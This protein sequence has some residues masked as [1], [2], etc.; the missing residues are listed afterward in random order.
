MHTMNSSL[1]RLYLEGQIEE[2]VMFSHS[3]TPKELKALLK[4]GGPK[5]A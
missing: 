4:E 2:E 3:P 1:H 5:N